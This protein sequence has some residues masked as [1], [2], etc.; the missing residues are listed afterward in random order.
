MGSIYQ[1]LHSS[2]SE[3]SKWTQARPGWCLTL[4]RSTHRPG[5]T[6]SPAWTTLTLSPPAPWTW[7]S[8]TSHS[9]SREQGTPSSTVSGRGRE[10]ES[11][12]GGAGT[13]WGRGRAGVKGSGGVSRALDTHNSTRQARLVIQTRVIASYFIYNRDPL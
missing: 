11:I 10:M 6:L 13:S 3:I 5:G 1:S 12:S 8:W 2:Q 9:R 4:R 7:T